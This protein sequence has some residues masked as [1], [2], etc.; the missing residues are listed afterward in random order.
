MW[1]EKYIITETD[2]RKLLA[3][4][5]SVLNKNGKSNTHV[6][7]LQFS[8]NAVIFICINVKGKPEITKKGGKRN[9]CIYR[10]GLNN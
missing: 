9:I 5:Q 2:F 1:V 6:S 10:I 4:I 8:I 3:H 7:K